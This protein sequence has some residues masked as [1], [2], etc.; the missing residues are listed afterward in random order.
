MAQAAAVLPEFMQVPAM[1]TTGTP[2]VSS[3]GSSAS[4]CMPIRAG[5][6][7]RSP[8][9][10]KSSTAPSTRASKGWPKLALMESHTPMTPPMFSSCRVSPT[11]SF[12]GMCPE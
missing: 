4:F 6:P 2:W 9:Y 3:T 12:S 11:A 10:G 5:T 1:A 7:M 8:R